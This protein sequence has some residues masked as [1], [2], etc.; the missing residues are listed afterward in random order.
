MF[1]LSLS[2]PIGFS[3]FSITGSIH[4]LI[5]SGCRFPSSA[6]CEVLNEFLFEFSITTRAVRAAKHEQLL[7]RRRL[8]P[9][10]RDRERIAKQLFHYFV[11][12]MSFMTRSIKR[13]HGCTLEVRSNLRFI[14]RRRD[15]VMQA[16]SR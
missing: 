15:K 10:T 13:R 5:R 12:I 7:A 9:F 1:S 4:G 2:F 16:T 8:V 14:V 11:F 3:N 6:P